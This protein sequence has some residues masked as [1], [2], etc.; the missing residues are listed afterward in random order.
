MSVSENANDHNTN[1]PDDQ[2]FAYSSMKMN[3]DK[4]VIFHEFHDIR[5]QIVRIKMRNCG[6]FPLQ[7]CC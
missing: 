2:T 7:Q 1:T 3:D 4:N 5:I 6:V